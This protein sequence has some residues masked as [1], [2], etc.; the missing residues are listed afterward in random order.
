MMI[1]P[2]VAGMT[3]TTRAWMIN[4][5]IR[6]EIPLYTSEELGAAQKALRSPFAPGE[7]V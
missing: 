1:R 6:L 3:T 2:D 4:P 5:W 7:W